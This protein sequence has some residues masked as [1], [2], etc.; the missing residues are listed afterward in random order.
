MENKLYRFEN[1]VN[2][3]KSDDK[4]AT[5][6]IV[7]ELEKVKMSRAEMIKKLEDKFGDEKI[8]RKVA[9]NIIHSDKINGKKIQGKT[10]DTKYLNI[11]RKGYNVA[12][13]WI[14]DAKEPFTEEQ[15]NKMKSGKYEPDLNKPVRK[16]KP[17]RKR[18]PKKKNESHVPKF[19][20]YIN[21]IEK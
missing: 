9:D 15:L 6:F 20:E 11:K 10:Y 19:G 18:T 2:E 12:Y 14:G 3:A 5:D 7:S 13:F 17:V 21:E 16:E 4:E 1:F 8:S